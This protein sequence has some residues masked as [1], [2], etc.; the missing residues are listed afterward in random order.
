V[1]RR[2]KPKRNDPLAELERLRETAKAT[3]SNPQLVAT[4]RFI[5]GLI[6][7]RRSAAKAGRRGDGA[8][9]SAVRELGTGVM[10]A[11]GALSEAQ[12]RRRGEVEVAI[13]FTDL[14]GFSAWALE[15]GDE[16][17]LELLN[18]VGET[19]EAAVSENGGAV[20]KRLGDGAMS[21]FGDA[22]EAVKAALEAQRRIKS[23][24]VQGHTPKLRAG[25]HVG[26]PQKVRKDFL[27]V[28]VNIAARVGEAAKAN[29]VLISGATVEALDGSEFR[30]G[31]SRELVAAG[32][33]E[34]LTVCS[35]KAK[36]KPKP[37]AKPKSKSKR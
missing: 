13:L 35:V 32:A 37:R 34:D 10:E 29:E 31:A 20:V 5:R 9:P 36:A 19:E 8:S 28:D 15:A 17:A 7:G 24:K 12:R 33:P 21:V 4:A 6:P 16:A 3:D 27:G 11:W 30:F 14:V 18:E 23:V 25:V 1:A 22:D 2:S 26:T